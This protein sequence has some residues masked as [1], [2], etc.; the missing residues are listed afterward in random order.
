[1]TAILQEEAYSVDTAENGKEAIA[2]SN[3]KPYNVALIDIRLPDIEGT[4]L[5]TK[6]KD[7]TP[8]M[9]KILV[10]G[11]PTL[12]NAIEAVNKRADAYLLKPFEIAKVIE[13]VKDQLKKQAEEMKYSEEKVAGFI[14]TRIRELE[15][16]EP[17][18]GSG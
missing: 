4:E 15:V 8:R 17:L 5:L 16:K 6:I 3:L 7:T 18:R 1:M 11:Y 10:T 9:R 13:T 2:K 12:S 14:E